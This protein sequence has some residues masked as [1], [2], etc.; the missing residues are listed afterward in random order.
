[1]IKEWFR[2]SRMG[3]TSGQSGIMRRMLRKEGGWKDHLAKT[4]EYIQ[5]VVKDQKP[6]SIRI[7]GSG[8]LLDVPIKFLIDNC[9]KIIL[10]DIIHPNQII[11]KYSGYKNI[12]F[13]TND[14]TGGVVD[15]GYQQKKKGYITTKYLYN[16]LK[17]LRTF[18]LKRIW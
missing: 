17:T 2:N 11:N 13:E 9:E 12:E 18:I 15:L 1:M 3:Y 16:K 14:I 7:L 8:W 4:S 6:R 10:T 5:Q